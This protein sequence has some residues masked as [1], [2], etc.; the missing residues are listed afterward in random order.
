MKCA[1]RLESCWFARVL[2][3]RLLHQQIDEL[4]HGHCGEPL[5]VERDVEYGLLLAPGEA[6]RDIR[7]ELLDQYGNTFLAPPAVADR[8]LDDDF[9]R[10]RAVVELHGDR[11]GDRAPLRIEVIARELLVLDALHLCA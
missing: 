3:A 9:L 10:A 5:R 6:P 8:I 7:A 4:V 11:V 1:G 2:Y